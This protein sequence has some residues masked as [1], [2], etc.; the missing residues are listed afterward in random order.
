VETTAKPQQ[1]FCAVAHAPLPFFTLNP[2]FPA[3]SK[4]KAP[5]TPQSSRLCPLPTTD[6]LRPLPPLPQGTVR[7]SVTPQVDSFLVVY[8]GSFVA[9]DPHPL[10]PAAV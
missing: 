9:S 7:L 10:E 6:K 5:T 1:S 3:M 2:E 8:L 4:S